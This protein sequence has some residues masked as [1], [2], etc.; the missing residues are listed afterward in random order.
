MKWYLL[1]LALF[2]IQLT[3]A[4]Q[5]GGNANSYEFGLPYMQHFEPGDYNARPDNQNLVQGKNGLMYIG[6]GSGVLEYDGVNFR[7]IK[8]PNQG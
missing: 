2:I 4:Q 6:N 5:N 1:F 7:L 8:L 3:K